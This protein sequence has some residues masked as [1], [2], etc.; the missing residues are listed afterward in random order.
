MNSWIVGWGI[1]GDLISVWKEVLTALGHTPT[2]IPW[3]QYEDPVQQVGVRLVD[4]K[5]D[6]VVWWN[7]MGASPEDMK[8][9]TSQCTTTKHIMFNMSDP[10]CW[11]VPANRMRE[12][13]KF[14]HAAIVSSTVNTKLYAKFGCQRVVAAHCPFSASNLHRS[15]GTYDDDVSF[16]LT[17]LYDSVDEYPDQ[18]ASRRQLIEALDKEPSIRFSVYGPAHLRDVAPNSYRRELGFE[19][20][21]DTFTSSKI[22]LSTHVTDAKGYLNRRTVEALSC[23]ALVLTDVTEGTKELGKETCVYLDGKSV[24]NQVKA[25]LADY[26]NMTTT[27]RSA[28]RYAKSRFY[29]PAFVEKVKSVFA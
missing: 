23:G 19:E 16:V 18:V 28:M 17:N 15:S 7:W 6:Y 14:F 5:P 3:L 11:S 20:M 13:V 1:D 24:V 29:V 21:L 8:H 4:E 12:R 2:F 9:L 27:K 25:I 22:V 26:K 10:Y